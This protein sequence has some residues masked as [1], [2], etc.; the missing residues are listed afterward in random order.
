MKKNMSLADRIARI[1]VAV[2]I[3]TLYFTD[4]VNGTTAVIAGVVALV[5]VIT[6]LL[7]SCP[8]YMLFGISTKKN[9]SK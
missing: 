4:Q 5:F 3:A 2:L 7:G 1:L 9:S 6:S 8:L